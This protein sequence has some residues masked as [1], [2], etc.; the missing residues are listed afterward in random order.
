MEKRTAHA[1]ESKD[2]WVDSS[3]TAEFI[4]G[5]NLGIMSTQKTLILGGS[6]FLG[7]YLSRIIDDERVIHYSGSSRELTAKNTFIFYISPGNLKELKRY[8]R[9]NGFTRIINCVANANVD[10]CEQFPDNAKFLNAEVAKCLAE[11]SQETGAKFVQIS[12][13]AVFDG[14]K[15]FRKEF[16]ICSPETVY[17]KTKLLGELE[18]LNTNP[19]SLVV[20]V[21]FFG[22]SE[23]KTSLFNYFLFGLQNEN[24]LIGYPD[25]FF[26]PLYVE[27]TAIAIRHLLDL[28]VSGVIHVAGKERIS[29]YEF[30][31]LIARVWGFPE[32]L[33]KPSDYDSTVNRSLDLSLDTSKLTDL[34][35]SFHTLE[36]S[37]VMLRESIVGRDL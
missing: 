6:G 35:M 18:V 10:N 5:L 19:N 17:G 9:E 21:N 34:G 8:I 12:T 23:K 29:K 1:S 7:Q 27:S 11:V 31:R 32:E 36:Q 25:I 22:L 2:L 13:D 24:A 26:T 16:D 33:I 14:K 3:K 37:L 28:D 15:S 4:E 20:R 30:G